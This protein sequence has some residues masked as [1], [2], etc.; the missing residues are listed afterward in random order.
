MNPKRELAPIPPDPKPTKKEIAAYLRKLDGWSN[1]EVRLR[2]AYLDWLADK[3]KKEPNLFWCPF[4][5]EGYQ[6]YLESKCWR[7]ISDAVK[8]EAGYKCACCPKKATDVHHRCYRPRVLSGEDTSLLIALCRDCHKK[9]DFD[10]RGKVRDAASKERT[11]S[12][13]YQRE[14]DR[15]NTP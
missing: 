12:E 11:L 9:V 4:A 13:L 1:E 5:P 7:A 2:M 15:L 8:K 10:E 14:T 3:S 6:D